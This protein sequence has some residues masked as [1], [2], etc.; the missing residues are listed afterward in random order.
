M[1]KPKWY[2]FKDYKDMT[3][4]Q[5]EEYERCKGEIITNYMGVPSSPS[6][7]KLRTQAYL[8]ETK[9]GFWD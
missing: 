2:E 3:P 7:I 9:K 6:S 5:K 4:E 8:E 1:R